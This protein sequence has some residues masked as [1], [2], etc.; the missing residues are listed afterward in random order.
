MV[1]PCLAFNFANPDPH[2]RIIHAGVKTANI[3]AKQAVV[4]GIIEMYL[5]TGH[6]DEVT[7]DR[8]AEITGFRL[9]D[10]SELVARLEEKKSVQMP[11][12]INEEGGL[13]GPAAD[14]RLER[15]E[16]DFEDPRITLNR[17]KKGEIK[18]WR[19]PVEQELEF[20]TEKQLITMLTRQLEDESSLINQLEGIVDY[21]RE[22]AEAFIRKTWKD[23]QDN[24]AQRMSKINNFVL[25]KKV[26]ERSLIREWIQE[27]TYNA[28][29]NAFEEQDA[30]SL[31]PDRLTGTT[32]AW[33]VSE[34][35][36]IT[37]KLVNEIEGKVK[38]VLTEAVLRDADTDEAVRVVNDIFEGAKQI[39]AAGSIT[40]LLAGLANACIARG[41]EMLLEKKADGSFRYNGGKEDEPL[42]GPDEIVAT[43]RSAVLDINTCEVCK[44]L[45]GKIMRID[46]PRIKEYKAPQLCQ[47]NWPK[48]G[49]RCRC[50]QF[51]FKRSMRE[52]FREENVPPYPAPLLP[53]SMRTGAFS[54]QGGK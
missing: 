42:G 51:H 49:N 6:I 9:Y 31:F 39:G 22:G 28:A 27:Q 35:R 48:W 18:L 34:P 47:G 11:G 12:T 30:L 46:D 45:D 41:R 10:A 43:M 25:R 3:A 54:R 7:N 29:Y 52:E 23:T 32:S 4:Q 2:I 8:L 38:T 14:K 1:R 37:D 5:K 53:A 16:H 20:Y 21:Q 50:L 36:R 24:H 33:A 19:K 13:I 26:E 40:W 44:K 17:I 15:H